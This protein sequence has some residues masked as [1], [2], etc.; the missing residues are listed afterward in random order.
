MRSKVKLVSF[1]TAAALAAAFLVYV[2]FF[3][4]PTACPKA[5]IYH[6]D[7]DRY[8]VL[9][10]SC[11]GLGNELPP[12]YSLDGGEFTP[13]VVISGQADD[14]YGF[15]SVL[16]SVEWS[17]GRWVVRRVRVLPSQEARSRKHLDSVY[18]HEIADSHGV[19]MYVYSFHDVAY[20]VD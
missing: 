12:V 15:C 3:R 9:L 2:L 7:E 18:S 5:V 8:E 13:G 10:G 14:D 16:W 1:T 6:V 19:G 4:S 11:D 20:P 17:W